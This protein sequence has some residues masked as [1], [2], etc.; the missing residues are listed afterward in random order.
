MSGIVQI[1][2]AVATTAHIQCFFFIIIIALLKKKSNHVVSICRWKLRAEKIDWM[3]VCAVC[4]GLSLGSLILSLCAFFFFNLYSLLLKFVL[5]LCWSRKSIGWIIQLNSV[6]CP[7][8]WLNVVKWNTFYCCELLTY[9]SI[10]WTVFFFIC[11]V[12]IYLSARDEEL[13]N[14]ERTFLRATCQATS[15]RS[16]TFANQLNIWSLVI[17]LLL[18]M[19]GTAA[20]SNMGN[21]LVGHLGIVRVFAS[22]WVCESVIR[23]H[24]GCVDRTLEH[25]RNCTINHSERHRLMFAAP[26]RRMVTTAR[27]R[28]PNGSYGITRRRRRKSQRCRPKK[29]V[30]DLTDRLYPHLSPQRRILP[31]L[32]FRLPDWWYMPLSFT[33]RHDEIYA[34][35]WCNWQQ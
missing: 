12:S 34:K 9:D 17:H 19:Y 23:H 18:R 33:R 25:K 4:A 15:T 22:V 29:P 11:S 32:I 10:R 35:I 13:M 8:I 28:I 30:S 3:C 14:A 20:A 5:L 7:A 24:F 31:P 1:T 2:E 26:V 6:V 27:A 21:G 16:S